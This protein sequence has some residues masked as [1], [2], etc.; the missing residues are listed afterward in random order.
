MLLPFW[1]E[2]KILQPIWKPVW[3]F[4]IKL[5]INLP[6][7][8]E[9][10]FL[11]ILVSLAPISIMSIKKHFEKK[12]SNEY[13]R[14]WLLGRIHKELLWINKNK[15]AEEES[16]KKQKQKTKTMNRQEGLAGSVS[17]HVTLDLR[18]VSLGIEITG[19]NK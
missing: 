5:N 17:E 3:K 16:D 9:I 1:Q 19:K 10:L 15:T 11:G 12:F 18:V 8:L 13:Y 4:L 6:Y 7:D 14:H 2:F